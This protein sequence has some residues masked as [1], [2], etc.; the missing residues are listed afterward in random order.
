LIGQVSSLGLRPWDISAGLSDCP[1]WAEYLEAKEKA[2]EELFRLK[3]QVR[4]LSGDKP[5]KILALSADYYGVLGLLRDM[6]GEIRIAHKPSDRKFTVSV[7]KK[8]QP[9]LAHLTEILNASE[10]GW[11]GPSNG[12]IIGSPFQGTE[13]SFLKFCEKIINLV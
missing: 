7:D 4:D 1:Q 5:Y 13:Y 12:L 8:F 10:P 9:W 2:K 6:G 3:S 11:G